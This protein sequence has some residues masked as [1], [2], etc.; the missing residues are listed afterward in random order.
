MRISASFT[1]TSGTSS[2]SAITSTDGLE[3]QLTSTIRR[4]TRQSLGSIG[5]LAIEDGPTLDAGL[6][7]LREAVGQE[8][9]IRSVNLDQGPV[10]A[11]ITIMAVIGPRGSLSDTVLYRLDQYVMRGG[12]VLFLLNG[13]EANL[14]AGPQQGGGIAFPVRSN[15]DSLAGFYGAAPS[16]SALVIDTRHLQI[17]A[18]QNLGFLQ[19]PVLIDYPF[20]VAASSSDPNHILGK[21]LDRIDLLFA[22]PLRIS[23]QPEAPVTVLV[24][25]SARSGLR[26]LPAMIMPPIE[27]PPEEYSAPAQPLVAAIEGFLGSYYA[28]ALQPSPQGFGPLLDSAFMQRSAGNRLLVVGDADLATDQAMSPYNQ[29]FLLNAFDWLSRNDL[30]I[31]LRSRQVQDRPLEQADPA[32][33]ARIKWANLLGPSLLVV[34]FGLVR[35]RR[36]AVAKRKG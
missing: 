2:T 18:M 26:T 25:S 11:D 3:Y 19:L 28:D 36:R 4:V 16:D 17:R 15:I 20:F 34:I 6:S 7:R 9:R 5:I 33:R 35:W 30:L 12:P 22:S 8:Y 14:Q 13:A 31:A 23:A 21:E 27:I 29:V 32:G 24:R 1:S 10:P